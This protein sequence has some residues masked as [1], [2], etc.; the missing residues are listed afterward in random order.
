MIGLI[1]MGVDILSLSCK[2]YSKRIGN[3]VAWGDMLLEAKLDEIISNFTEEYKQG[4]I[5]LN[6]QAKQGS[7]KKSIIYLLSIFEAF[8]KDFILEIE[9]KEEEKDIENILSTNKKNWANYCKGCNS[10]INKSTSFMNI[11]YSLFIL[12][13]RYGIKYL[14][15]LTNLVLELGSLRNCIVHHDGNISHTDKGGECSFKDTLKET[16]SFLKMNK[17]DDN[18]CDFIT[19]E[20]VKK[21]TFDLQKIIIECESY[22]EKYNI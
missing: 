4:I 15:D 9:K 7:Y 11:R 5:E 21:V 20:Y 10:S 19:Y 3:E 13:N 8:M 12:E 16:I 22:L 6:K 17:N 1:I 2:E 18:I 14:Q